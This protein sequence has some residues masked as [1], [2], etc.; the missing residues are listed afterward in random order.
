MNPNSCSGNVKTGLCPGGNDNKCCVPKEK[1]SQCTSVGGQCMNP[2]SCSGNVKTGLCPGGNDNKCCVPKEKESKC[3]SAGG[4]CMNPDNC[5]GTVKDGLC[6]GGNDNK[7]CVP[8]EKESKCTSAGGQCMNPDNC[9]GIVKDGLCPGGNDNKCCVTEIV[10]IKEAA[11]LSTAF[12]IPTDWTCEEHDVCFSALMKVSWDDWAKGAERTCL[13][14]P[15]VVFYED[16]YKCNLF[17][18]EMLLE[19]GIDVGTPN[20]RNRVVNLPLVGGGAEALGFSIQR[21]PRAED[22]YNYNDFINYKDSKITEYFD[23]ILEIDDR[24]RMYELNGES[25]SAY[26][27]MDYHTRP[28]DIVTTGSH[29]GIISKH[30]GHRIGER[31]LTISAGDYRILHNSFGFRSSDKPI[32]VF[33]LQEI[34]LK[35]H[36]TN[37]SSDRK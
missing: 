11:G 17:V 29:I 32:R 33:R 12:G 6:P 2:N 25:V 35:E 13:Y 9:P 8:K 14:N 28:G 4:Q 27:Y 30:D 22:W 10:T 16:E 20:R 21:P 31:E 15:D 3:T 34:F 37:R 5:S 36:V 26:T 19:N 23:F 18:Y 7:C 24:D 1:E